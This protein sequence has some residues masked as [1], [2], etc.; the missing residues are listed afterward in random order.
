MQK[1]DIHHGD[2]RRI[3]LNLLVA[4]DALMQERHVSRAAERLF[5]GQPAMSHMLSRLRDTLKDPL[6]VRSGNRMEPTARA[7]ELAPRIRQWLDEANDFLF[8]ETDF[9]PA[10]VTA[11]FSL[12][13]PDGLEALLFPSLIAALRAEAPGVQLRSLLLETDQ[14]LAALDRDEVDLLFTAAPL[15]LRDWHNHT[16][17]SEAGFSAVYSPRQTTLPDTPTLADLAACDQLVSS[18]RGTAAGVVDHLFTER[19]LT[20]RIVALSASLM[21][22]GHILSEAPLISIQ[23]NLYLPLFADRPDL[24]HVPLPSEAT[25][26]INLVWH[27]RNDT[28]PLH[29]YLRALLMRHFEQRFPAA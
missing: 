6:F 24:V 5:L 4:F 28:H 25:L 18:H 27:R 20:R 3:D 1:I 15:P 19:G 7:L 2:L 14:Q 29:R 9:D 26:C 12:S 22:T 11:R 23:P 21:A 17:L 10:A 16:I 8:R 13:A